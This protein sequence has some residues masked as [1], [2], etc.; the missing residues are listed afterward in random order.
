MESA[1]VVELDAEVAPVTTESEDAPP[2]RRLRPWLFIRR[3]AMAVASVFEWLFGLLSL[4]LG[5]SMLAALPLLQFLSLGYFLE[6]SARV[7]RTGRLRDG[8]VGVRR[9]AP[10]GG[11]A[12]GILLSPLPPLLVWSYS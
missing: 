7:A 3:A 2:S 4:V 1:V 9:A 10:V 11:L 8:F 6:S 12:A 5:L